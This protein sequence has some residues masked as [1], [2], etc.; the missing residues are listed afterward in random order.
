MFDANLEA[1]R[2]RYPVLAGEMAR[3]ENPIRLFPSQA[4]PMTGEILTANGPMLLHSR[5]D[6]VREAER[7]T[8][9]ILE[10]GDTVLI[11]L[12]MGL[13]Y[14]VRELVRNRR[15]RFYDLLVV[16]RDPG[17]FRAALESV[18]LSEAFRDDRI[19]F[20]IGDNLHSVLE[21][22]RRILPGIMSSRVRFYR[23][24]TAD[25]LNGDYYD[26]VTEE[27]HH[28]V[29]HTA[30]EFQLMIQ[31]GRQLQEN[32]WRNLTHILGHTGIVEVENLLPNVP[33][34]IIAA[35]PSL[36]RNLN[37]LALVK[38]SGAILC[39]DTSYRLLQK[40]GIVP[41]FVVATDPSELNERHFH[42]LSFTSDPILAFDPEV[43]H[44]IPALVPWRRLVM[45]LEK[46]A[47]TRWFEQEFGPWGFVEK[48]GS[49][50]NTAFSLARIL[51][52]N[53][54]VFVGLDLAYDPK[55]GA[56]H[57]GG[58]ALARAFESIA[59]GAASVTMDRHAATNNRLEESLVWVPGAM[60]GQVPTSR[61]MA[62]YIRKFQEEVALCGRRVIDSTEGGALIPGTEILPLCQSVA[63]Y[64]A[65]D[66]AV[67]Q[68]LSEKVK[69]PQRVDITRVKNCINNV[70]QSLFR[71][72]ELAEFG[73]SLT[74]QLTSCLSQGA[75]L[76]DDPTWIRMEET[77]N[78]IYRDPLVKVGVE[79]ALFSAIYF[80]CQKEPLDAVEERLKKYRVFFEKTRTTCADFRQLISLVGQASVPVI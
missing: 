53:P 2:T 47:T 5:Y 30:A 32:L 69:G 3:T 72:V 4:G 64:C 51:G 78:T 9:S 10:E 56:S 27:I 73:Q 22:A 71:A 36:N 24:R 19:H 57:A 38:D 43:Y 44:T 41:H 18:D 65:E 21:M 55:G 8:E 35:G 16:E 25:T 70:A 23:T 7:E 26:R 74:E 29:E 42:G 1:V 40:A 80:F 75:A 63:A 79:Q 77:F 50:A 14:V 68:R 6:P 60:G 11:L 49:V 20:A 15:D 59:P 66:R 12:G 62:L 61:I 28:L 31:S 37:D 54:I 76:R 39:V 52:C 45:N 48:G 33:A 58:T 67:Q 13:G 46:C 34:F 17:L